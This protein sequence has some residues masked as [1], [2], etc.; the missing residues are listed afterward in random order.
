MPLHNVDAE[1]ALLSSLFINPKQIHF[2]ADIVTDDSFYVTKHQQIYRAIAAL[3]NENGAVDPITVSDAL[4]KQGANV[5]LGD[6]FDVAER[7]PTGEL[8]VYYAEIVAEKCSRRRVID[9]IRKAMHEVGDGSNDVREIVATVQK[10][11]DQSLPSDNREKVS[12]VFPDIMDTW[13][14]VLDIPKGGEP[15]Y[16]PTGFYDLDREVNL[17]RGTL[18]IIGASPREGK[19]S[20]ILCMMRNIAKGG[21]RPLL[22]TLEM[23]R[24]RILENLLAQEA[25]ICHRDMITGRLTGEDEKKAGEVVSRLPKLNIGV[26][27]GRWSAGQIRHRVIQEQR[28]GQVDAVFVDV[29]GKMLPPAGLKAADLHRVFNTNCQILQDMAIE[30]NIPV[31]LAAHLN[32]DKTRQGGDGRPNLFSLREA[33]EE[34]SD[35]VILI[36]R[37][38]LRMPT[39]DNQNLAEIIIAKNRDGDVGTIELFFDGP[40]KTFK[41]IVRRN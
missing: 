24:E 10:E 20:L 11:L 37:E 13:E 5:S 31:I 1:K 4:V 16:L 9:S 3:I 23:S 2:I 8:A 21:K 12:S 25:G 36:H 27:D 34:F 7:M 33:G 38:Y 22:F 29:L 17:T 14:R 28:D 39:P 32:R 30:L 26:L 6:V 15:N 35:N 18:T 40:T 19:T 41:N